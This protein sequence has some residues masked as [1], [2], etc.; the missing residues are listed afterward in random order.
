MEDLKVTNQRNL[1][2]IK[3][4]KDES[5]I[6]YMK[7][8]KN[9]IILV[10]LIIST[11][12]IYIMLEVRTES[13]LGKI[14]NIHTKMTEINDKIENLQND[15]NRLQ[16][17]FNTNTNENIIYLKIMI[18]NNQVDEKLAKDIS[19]YLYK[20]S[21]IYDRDPDLILALIKIESNFNP[22]VISNA[23]ATGLTQIM[24]FWKEIFRTDEDFTN[25]ETSIKYCMQ[26][27]ALYEKQYQTID[28]ALIAYNRG[29][30]QIETSLLQGVDPKNGYSA[31]IMDLYKKLKGGEVKE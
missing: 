10:S 8:L 4:E 19:K 5:D 11:I 15:I 27:L 29:N 14:N 2:A 16:L 18:L 20:Y 25:V 31:K 28:M 7:N 30:H 6:S 9:N 24:P 12:F 23:G 21:K 1:K 22:K 17:T 13:V 3:G 26:I